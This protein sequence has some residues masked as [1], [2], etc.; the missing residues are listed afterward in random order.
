MGQKWHKKKTFVTHCLDT[1]KGNNIVNSMSGMFLK[2]NILSKC[3]YKVKKCGRSRTEYTHQ[4]YTG[5]T[6]FVRAAI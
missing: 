3:V 2:D 4:L 5:A 1:H 6:L